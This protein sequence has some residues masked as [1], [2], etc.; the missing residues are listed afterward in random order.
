MTCI[1]RENYSFCLNWSKNCNDEIYAVIDE[2]IIHIG[3]LSDLGRYGDRLS[4]G[5]L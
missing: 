2:E 1:L 5:G 4:S 3:P